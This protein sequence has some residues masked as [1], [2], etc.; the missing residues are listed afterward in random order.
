MN[1]N[2]LIIFIRNPELGKCKTRLAKTVG[3]ENAFE[4]YRI[5]L[6]HTFEIT[7]HL[8]SDKAIYYSENIREDDIWDNN[9][10]QKFQQKGEDLGMRMLNSFENSFLSKYEHVVIIGSDILDL[11]Q[12]HIESAFRALESNDVVLGPSEDGGYYLLGMKKLYPVI[13]HNKKW[14]TETVR[15][16]TLNELKSQK[17]ILL[18]LLNDIDVYNDIKDYDILKP[19]LI[20]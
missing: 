2:L 13:F 3:N 15:C 18:E 16:E 5:L 12:K 4:I 10:Y 8:R 17:V 1:K 9:I 11:K 6:K 19:F 7:K 20:K 14:G